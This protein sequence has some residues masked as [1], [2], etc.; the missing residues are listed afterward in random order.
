VESHGFLRIPITSA[1]WL[2]LSSWRYLI[3][4][5]KSFPSNALALW[6]WVSS[7]VATSAVRRSPCGEPLRTSPGAILFHFNEKSQIVT[8]APKR[9][10]RIQTG[11]RATIGF[12]AHQIKISAQAN[13]QMSF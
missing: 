3:G 8:R 1:I 2:A 12:N 7:G 6:R 11:G 13:I 9:T 5:R 10:V 4:N